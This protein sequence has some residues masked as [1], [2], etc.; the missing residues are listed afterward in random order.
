RQT[1]ILPVLPPKPLEVVYTVA[2]DTKVGERSGTKIE[3]KLA[4]S[5]PFKQDLNGRTFELTDYSE[6][7]AVDPETGQV[8]SDQLHERLEVSAGNQKAA[9]DFTAAAT[10]QETHQLSPAELASRIKQAETIDRL[11]QGLF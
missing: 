5:L 6:T 2:G 10:L 7:I 3:K 11:Q 4:Q 9:L 1:E 8:L